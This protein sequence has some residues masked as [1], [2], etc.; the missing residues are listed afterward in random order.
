MIATSTG[1]HTTVWPVV[2]PVVGPI[3]GS[4]K[5][6][7]DYRSNRLYCQFDRINVR[8]TVGPIVGPI[9]GPTGPVGSCK[10]RIT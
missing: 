6:P 7:F 2:G 5:R 9:V 3:V 10:R 4:S 8:Q 1:L